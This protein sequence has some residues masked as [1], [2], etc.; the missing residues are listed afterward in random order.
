MSFNL[1]VAWRG[2]ARLGVYQR[3]GKES[4]SYVFLSRGLGSRNEHSDQA[5]VSSYHRIAEYEYVTRMIIITISTLSQGSSCDYNT[6]QCNA[7][8]VMRLRLMFHRFMS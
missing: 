8:V 3:I 7:M 6:I 5:L 4:R 1:R 2:V